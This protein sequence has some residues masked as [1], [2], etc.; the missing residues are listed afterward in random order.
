MPLLLKNVEQYHQA[1]NETEWENKRESRL[2]SVQNKQA[3]VTFLIRVIICTIRGSVLQLGK[4]GQQN[5]NMESY[6]HE[7]IEPTQCSIEF[8][9]VALS[10]PTGN[11]SFNLP[12]ETVEM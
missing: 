8:S 10:V 1:C 2:I 5:T 11:I 3:I 12:N 6:S 7:R 9:N 4:R